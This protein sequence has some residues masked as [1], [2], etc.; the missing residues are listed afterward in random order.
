MLTMK[1]CGEVIKSDDQAA[2]LLKLIHIL[3]IETTTTDGLARTLCLRRRTQRLGRRMNTLPESSIVHNTCPLRIDCVTCHLFEIILH[4][5]R[6]DINGG[7]GN[8]IDMRKFTEG[9]I[10]TQLIVNTLDIRSGQTIIDAGC[11][12][13][14]MAKIFSRAVSSSGKV[15]AI[16]RDS[17][18]IGQLTDDVKSTNIE[19]IEGDITNLDR[20]TDHS[21]DLLFASTVIHSIPKKKMIDFVKEAKRLLKPN[22][23]LAIVEIEKKETPFGPAMENR[24]SPEELIQKISMM[25][26]KTIRVGEH[27]YM[28]VFLNAE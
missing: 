10:D 22:A 25:P 11:G 1:I 9:L 14:Y 24:Y 23:A 12:T 16:D 2:S 17:Y 6:N 19:A 18:F 7:K 21:V 26:E 8:F 20:I 15:Y 28:Q 3:G 4:L 5:A 27:F 13:G